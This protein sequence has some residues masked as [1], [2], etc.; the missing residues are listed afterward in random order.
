LFEK[1]NLSGDFVIVNPFLLRDLKAAGLWTASIAEQ[2]KARDGDLTEIAAIPADLKHRYRTAFQIP[3][4]ALI[5][6]AARRQK[7][8]DHSQSLDLFLAE[9]DM[10]TMSHM[11]RHPWH[12]GLK[13]TYYLRTLGTSSIGKATVSARASTPEP[14]ALAAGLPGGGVPVDPAGCPIEAMRTGG[15]CEACQ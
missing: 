6:A 10:K 8:L 12:S 7:W 4:D 3:A 2:L 9:P 5:D 14:V 13:T 11:Y 15:E 1:S